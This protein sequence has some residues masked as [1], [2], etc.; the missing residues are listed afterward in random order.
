VKHISEWLPGLAE[1]L[2]NRGNEPALSIKSL[3]ELNRKIW[4]IRQGALTVI[5][6]RTSQGKSSFALQIASDLSS[7]KIPVWLLSLEMSVPS[8][9]ER[10]FCH[11]MSV[12]N[13]SVL[14]GQMKMDKGIQRKYLK[15]KEI[16]Q[17]SSL[18][19]TEG[20][21]KNWEDVVQLIEA[22]GERPKVV[23]V[24]YI[25]NIA[26][27]SGDTREIINDYIR[28]FRNLAIKHNFA[29]ILCSQIN[30]G[31]EQQKNNEPTLAQLKETGF[32]EESA[33]MVMLL[34]WKA[35]Y[36]TIDNDTT[37]YSIDVAKNRNGRTGEHKLFYTP[38]YYRF[39]EDPSPVIEE[40]EPDHKLEAAGDK[41]T[42]QYALDLFGG[43]IIDPERDIPRR[44]DG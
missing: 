5:G 13:Y 31:A 15:F 27:R 36:D 32:L 1:E 20:I 23:I 16:M 26:F 3:P 38:K 6:A 14:S 30:R 22:V 9:I 35:F 28:R 18:L 17:D 44:K 11:M 43:K 24:D 2:Y 41:D 33:D 25:Q 4:G 34:H 10:L 7:Q 12:D 29:G 8:L 39:T 42:V 40:P 19:I 37:P 21:G